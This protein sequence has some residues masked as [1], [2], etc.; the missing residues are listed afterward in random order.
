MET[1]MVSGFGQIFGLSHSNTCMGFPVLVTQRVSN[2]KLKPFQALWE[3][4]LQG[5]SNN[6]GGM[7]SSKLSEA[8]HLSEDGSVSLQHTGKGRAHA[9]RNLKTHQLGTELFHSYDT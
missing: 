3:M 4:E 9:P 2:L 8:E 6:Q 1:M 5:G 7:R